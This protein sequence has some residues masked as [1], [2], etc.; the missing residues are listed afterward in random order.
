VWAYVLCCIL[1]GWSTG[2]RGLF[3][4]FVYLALTF[5]G[6]P[7][8]NLFATLL[9]IKLLYPYIRVRAEM[10]TLLQPI[11]DP[12]FIPWNELYPK[13]KRGDAV[14]FERTSFRYSPNLT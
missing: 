1:V 11:D 7:N 2:V 9:A 13:L 12:A 14:E 8:F 5:M 10:H 6:I 4:V 3:A